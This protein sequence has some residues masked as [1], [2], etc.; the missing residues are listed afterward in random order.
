MNQLSCTATLT[1][2][3]RSSPRPVLTREQFQAF[4]F[5][6]S[7][8]ILHSSYPVARFIL[9]TWRTWILNFEGR[10]TTDVN[11]SLRNLPTERCILTRL[12]LSETAKGLGYQVKA[13]W[14][15]QAAY[16]YQ[17][18]LLGTIR[19]FQHAAQRL[20]SII[21]ITINGLLQLHAFKCYYY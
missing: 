1:H 2:V 20:S 13:N 8:E 19:S 14:N 11:Y 21:I 16:S 9:L 10:A 17:R 3:D 7:A 6:C 5:K 12:L 4:V 15:T 18:D